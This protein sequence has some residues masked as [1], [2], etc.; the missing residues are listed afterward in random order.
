MSPVTARI[1]N[2]TRVHFTVTMQLDEEQ[3]RALDALVGYGVDSFLD[4]FYEGLGRG[5]LEPY[6]AGLRRLF[7]AVGE[8][9]S[10]ELYRIDAARKALAAEPES[11]KLA[12]R[13]R[14]APLVRLLIEEIDGGRPEVNI[15]MLK[16]MCDEAESV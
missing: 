11:E 3:A 9:V 10:P 15:A 8:E 6:E 14:W 13:G 1:S 16:A 2:R 12:E 4:C 7:A 5:Y